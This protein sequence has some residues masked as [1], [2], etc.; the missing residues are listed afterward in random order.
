MP[1][2]ILYCVPI[3]AR[4]GVERFLEDVIV[5]HDPDRVKATVLA[6]SDGKW[7]TEL[8]ARQV[9]VYCLEGMRLRNPWRVFRAVESILKKERI[10]LVHS[11]YSWC[12]ALSAPAAAWKGCKSIWFHHG[13]M[14]RQLWQ[15]AM[16]LIPADLVLA[17]SHFLYQRLN[18][19]MYLAK[20]TAVLHYGI[21]AACFPRSESKRRSFREQWGLAS[22]DIAVGLIGFIDRWKGQ[23]IFLQ[24]ALR[25]RSAVPR[26]RMF[27]VG[28]PRQG[29][30]G[31]NCARFEAELKAFVAANGLED[32]VSFTGH[33]DVREGVLDGLD[34][35]VHAST[36]PEPFGMV[37]LEAMAKGKAIIAS[38]QGGPLEIFEDGSDG[39][40]IQPGD[41]ELLAAQ[42][43]KLAADKGL[44]EMLGQNAQRA[45]V[46]RF[47]ADR[48][49]RQ[50]ERYYEELM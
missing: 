37:L 8:A 14:S 2:N 45:V 4:G 36:E 47:S 22:D 20:R 48:A 6:F 3:G 1:A 29:S 49:T 26:V 44:R 35:F 27:V 39:Q 10:D 13:P 30:T 16:P 42:I 38:N 40:L 12:H 28:G 25:L 5:R 46:E 50:L 19:S 41:P 34:I 15:G 9:N 31:D 17:N 11:A 32:L 18:R 23:D 21:D 24:A 43:R 7:L 33:V